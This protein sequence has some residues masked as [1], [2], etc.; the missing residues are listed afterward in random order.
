MCAGRRTA[1]RALTRCAATKCEPCASCGQ[2]PD[3]SFV[4]STERGGPFTPDAINKLVKRIGV[5]AGFAFQ[6]HAHMLRHACGF[7][8]ADAGRKSI[9]HTTRYTQLSTAPFKDFWR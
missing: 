6:I 9:Q 2:F 3:S 7:A 8:L 5:R 1:C 4:F